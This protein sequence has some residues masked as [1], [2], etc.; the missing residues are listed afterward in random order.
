MQQRA[1]ARETGGERRALRASAS[2]WGL[3]TVVPAT[4]RLQGVN[5][6]RNPAPGWKLVIARLWKLWASLPAG[7][8]ETTEW[9][10][11]GKLG[12]ETSSYREGLC[13]FVRLCQNL[14]CILK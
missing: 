13:Y 4:P 1:G 2:G 10:W 5:S 7:E 9:G 14:F 3:P 8:M 11:E 12:K 6:V